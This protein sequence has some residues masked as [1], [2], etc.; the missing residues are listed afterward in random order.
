MYLAGG[1]GDDGI[2]FVSP[3]WGEHGRYAC[4]SWRG[5]KINFLFLASAYMPPIEIYDFNPDEGDQIVLSPSFAI[6]Q[7]FQGV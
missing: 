4:F 2:G 5:R 7:S 6:Y 3:Y 1:A